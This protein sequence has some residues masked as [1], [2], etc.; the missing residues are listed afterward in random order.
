MNI[1]KSFIVGFILSLSGVGALG[2]AS[3]AA[4]PMPTAASVST[5]AACNG[6]SQIDSA[7]G[8]TANAGESTITGIIR[9]VINILSYIIG[10]VAVI[11]VIVAGFKYTK[12]G[13]DSNN[14]SSAKNTLIYALV[15]LAVAALAQALVHFVFSAA[16][17]SSTKCPYATVDA[18]GT[19]LTGITS[20]DPLCHK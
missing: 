6:L 9:A 10:I 2:V 5:D 20:G 13:G 17:N 3:A 15:G 8:C 14:V 1:V 11:M 12:S 19:V 4:L 18:N 16:A 7:Q